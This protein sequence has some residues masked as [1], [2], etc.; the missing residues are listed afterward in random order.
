MFM[1]FAAATDADTPTGLLIF[2]GAMGAVAV[3]IGARWAFNL[4]GA[5]D[6]TL[7]RRR[8]VLEL[9]GQR[10]GDLGLA[11]NDSIGP[12]FFRI[13]GSVVAVAGFG[14][15]ALSSILFASA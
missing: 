4:R 6:S 11:V 5:V 12:S 10:T 14:L 9:K 3:I 7:Q 13:I 15:L 1:I 8:A 2:L